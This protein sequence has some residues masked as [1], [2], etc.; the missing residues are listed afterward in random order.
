MGILGWLTGKDERNR[1]L[2]KWGKSVPVTDKQ[3]DAMWELWIA[4]KNGVPP[5]IDP[6][7][8]L[9]QEDK[10]YILKICSADFRPSEFG[11]ANVLRLA[12][13]RHFKELGFTEDQGAVLVGMMF[14]MVGR[15]DI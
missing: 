8:K 2:A 14:N 4:G 15:Q 11:N 12:S 1:R 3:K 9:S 13:W 5:R 6:L 7:S 10:D